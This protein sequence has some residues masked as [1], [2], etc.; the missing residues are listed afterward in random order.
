MRLTVDISGQVL[1]RPAKLEQYLLEMPTFGWVDD[2][3]VLVDEHFVTNDPAI[4][5]AGDIAEYPDPILLAAAPEGS[6]G[7]RSSGAVDHH[8][9]GRFA[10]KGDVELVSAPMLGATAALV[11][12]GVALTVFAGPL[13]QLADNAAENLGQPG[14]YVETVLRPAPLQAEEAP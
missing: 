3:G 12:V 1:G 7:L 13:F 14:R 10:G 9:H 6:R 2:D 8:E 11:A 4:W 5:A